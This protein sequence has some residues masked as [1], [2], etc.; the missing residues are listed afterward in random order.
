MKYSYTEQADEVN[1]AT[2]FNDECM[3]EAVTTL[4]AAALLEKKTLVM[5]EMVKVI[6]EFC[7]DAPSMNLS[8][9]VCYQTD[10]KKLLDKLK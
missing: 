3:R 2:G 4:R 9:I 5:D 1:R 10:F 6:Q 8:E 7:A